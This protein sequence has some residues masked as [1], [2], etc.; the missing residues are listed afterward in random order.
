MSYPIYVNKYISVFAF[1]LSCIRPWLAGFDISTSI[2]TIIINVCIIIGL[3]CTIK[4]IIVFSIVYTACIYFAFSKSIIILFDIFFLSYNL[5]YCKIQQLASLNLCFSLIALFIIIESYAIGI[6]TFHTFESHKGGIVCDL[7][8]NNTNTLAMFFTNIVFMFGILIPKSRNILITLIILFFGYII[9]IITRSRTATGSIIVF[10]LTYFVNSFIGM[11]KKGIWI[12]SL[13]PIL[14]T[15]ALFY[16]IIIFKNYPELNIL[17]SGR[18]HIF[19]Y[20]FN[21]MNL[22]QLIFGTELEE[23]AYD[24]SY[25]MLPIYGGFPLLFGVLL[26]CLKNIRS[27]S[28]SILLYS[29]FIVGMLAYGISESVLVILSGMSLIF[30]KIITFPQVT[31]IKK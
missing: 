25:Y 4:K 19:E 1:G 16:L 7:G 18:L 26:C 22:S 15:S 23:G 12:I 27:S 24:G 9:F 17:A 14:I 31:I 20:W 2:I 10:G 11:G 8:F 13:L 30:W 21:N 28:P 29:P 6:I 5:R 3:S